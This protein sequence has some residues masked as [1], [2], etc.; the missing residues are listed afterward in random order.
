MANVT[1]PHN[2]A[3]GS[4]VITKMTAVSYQPVSVPPQP[5]LSDDNSVEIHGRSA[6]VAHTG[7]ITMVDKVAADLLVAQ[8]G[9]RVFSF[10]G[11]EADAA[12]VSQYS[13]AG[14]FFSAVGE[15]VTL[16]GASGNQ[17][18]FA[19]KALTRTAAQSHT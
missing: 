14:C 1:N 8:A 2:G 12:T 4:T 13:F 7:T 10:D 19:A 5:V 16:G 9:P 15:S 17:L 6:H 18:S 3:F 11:E